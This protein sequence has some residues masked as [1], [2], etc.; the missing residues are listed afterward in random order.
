MQ[1]IPVIGEAS[2][3]CRNRSNLMPDQSDWDDLDRLA[4]SVGYE[5]IWDFLVNADHS[6]FVGFTTGEY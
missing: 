2:Q 3:H 4:R 1:F 5:D 6:N